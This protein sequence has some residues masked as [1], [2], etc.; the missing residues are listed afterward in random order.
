M[1]HQKRGIVMQRFRAVFKSSQTVAE[2]HSACYTAAK[3]LFYSCVGQFI[4]KRYDL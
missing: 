1:C 3:Y 4:A 2:S